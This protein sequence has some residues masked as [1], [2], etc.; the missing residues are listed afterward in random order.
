MTID[1]FRSLEN[2]VANLFGY[3]EAILFGRARSALSAY[4]GLIMAE[5]RNVAL[6]PANICPAVFATFYDAGMTI[7][8]AKTNP[9]TGLADDD[10]M[11]H[12]ILNSTRSG[13]V[14]PA[15]LYGFVEPYSKTLTAARKMGWAVLENDSL[16]T[17]SEPL[18]PKEHPPF[19]DALLV[20]F[21]YSKTIEAGG[22]GAITTNDPSLAKE[23]RKIAGSFSVLD[24]AAM[25]RENWI[26]QTRRRLRSS[27]LQGSDTKGISVQDLLNFEMRELRYGFSTKL[28]TSLEAALQSYTTEVNERRDRLALWDVELS[29][30]ND[31]LL[32]PVAKQVVPWRVIRRISNK[33][34]C[35]V[36][37]LRA[38]NIDAGTNFPPLTDLF[39]ALL[40]THRE[41]GAKLWGQH[42]FNLWLTPQY[43]A[44]CIRNVTN[45]IKRALLQ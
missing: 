27:P 11:A 23:L 24:D 18:R 34:D 32:L 4:L 44:K 7:Q 45:L 17:K 1:S 10:N 35:V 42:V 40:S 28:A 41:E 33:R 37:A 20:S 38:E 13:I 12:Q 30:L 29:S 6:L 2:R 3:G 36:T 43:D 8:F 14:M 19:G 31:Q 21:G 22:G 16:A 39:P 26:M 25:E 9:L 5:Q 15:H